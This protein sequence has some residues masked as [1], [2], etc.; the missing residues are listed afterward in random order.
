MRLASLLSVL[1][2]AC[3]LACGCTLE[4]PSPDPYNS[5]VAP[6]PGLERA[7]AIVRAEWSDRLGVDLPETLPEIRY[8]L[9]CLQYPPEFMQQIWYSG[10][11]EGRYFSSDE[12]VH[13]RV[14]PGGPATD[15][16]AHELLHWALEN[17]RGDSNSEHDDPIWL[18]VQ[19]VRD[20]LATDDLCLVK[21]DLSTCDGILR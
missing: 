11:I 20:V 6:P 7:A 13:V 14:R 16:L 19:A 17:G 18:E 15:A 4:D 9:G 12:N 1:A 10:C 8:Y 3:A 21:Y 2:L 5:E